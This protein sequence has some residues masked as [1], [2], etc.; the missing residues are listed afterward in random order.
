[1]PGVF[2]TDMTYN[3][4]IGVGKRFDIA[5]RL[6]RATTA[7]KAVAI[8]RTFTDQRLRRGLGDYDGSLFVY[9]PTAGTLPKVPGD[10][11]SVALFGF[12]HSDGYPDPAVDDVAA[13]IA[14]WM[15]AVHSPVAERVN[16]NQ[17]TEDDPASRAIT[18]TLARDATQASATALQRSDPAL[19]DALWTL[20]LVVSDVGTTHNYSTSPMPPSDT[21]RA[22]WSDISAVIGRYYDADGKTHPRGK[23]DQTET[24]IE[25]NIDQSPEAAENIQRIGRGVAAL[26]PRFGHPAAMVVQTPDGPIE[27]L[28]GGC[29]RHQPDHR[30]LPLELELSKLYEKC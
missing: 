9:Y 15:H 16:L 1:M 8:G 28:V 2:A 7:D 6:E 21:E 22:L 14:A 12:G 23:T 27:I 25:I 13:S 17:P 24:H 10:E 20:S 18:V 3:S 29:Y 4:G 5:V 19:D 11:E 30:R 26:L